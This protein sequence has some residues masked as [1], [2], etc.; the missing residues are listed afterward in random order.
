MTD[1]TD[2]EKQLLEI[3]KNDEAGS[4]SW[5]LKNR[6]HEEGF[7]TTK[8]ELLQKLETKLIAY[9]KYLI[10]TVFSPSN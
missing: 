7:D 4:T 5:R 2:L 10:S 3:D 6:Y 8:R 1:I 9:G